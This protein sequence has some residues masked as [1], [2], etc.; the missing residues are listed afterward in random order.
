MLVFVFY[1]YLPLPDVPFPVVEPF[2]FPTW[3]YKVI[4]LKYKNSL[5]F[6]Q[7]GS[8]FT[9]AEVIEEEADELGGGGCK[10][11]GR[12][13]D[14]LTFDGCVGDELQCK[15]KKWI[16]L[17]LKTAGEEHKLSLFDAFLTSFESVAQNSMN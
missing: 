4:D 14:E 5:N 15:S 6:F 2:P 9:I 8:K 16:N 1:I 7:C 3:I 13:D 10:S 17:N 12:F 11:D